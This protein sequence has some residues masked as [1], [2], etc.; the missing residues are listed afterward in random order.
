[1]IAH[2]LASYRVVAGPVVLPFTR[3]TL[4]I[5][6]T[7]LHCSGITDAVLSAAVISALR[8]DKVI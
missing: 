2:L 5:F 7:A 8:I 4:S 1:M 3:L 6:I